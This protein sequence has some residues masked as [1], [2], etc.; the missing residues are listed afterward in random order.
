M[1][2]E[3]NESA[4]TTFRPEITRRL[5]D[6]P[7]PGRGRTADSER[8]GGKKLIVGRDIVLNGKIAACDR[9]VVEGSV[10]ATLENSKVIEI[11]ESGVYKG[12]AE[13]EEAIISGRFEGTLI[14][15]GQLT[16]KAT[17]RVSGEVRYGR[18]AIES[19]GIVT[20]TLETLSGAQNVSH[21]TAVEN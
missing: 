2:N 14:V 18:I 11:A 12:T 3:S 8:E 20:G 9:L 10:E 6:I 17:G 19:G 4:P 7:G 13:I 15:R 5:P 16:I 21:V 1:A